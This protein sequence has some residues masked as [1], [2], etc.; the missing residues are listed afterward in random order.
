MQRFCVGRSHFESAQIW[1]DYRRFSLELLSQIFNQNR[2]RIE[3]IHRDVE[4]TLHLLCVQVHGQHTAHTGGVQQIRD[5]F[6]RNRD[7]GLVFPV[8][9]RI[10]KKWNDCCNP[11]RAGAPRRVYH[12]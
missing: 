6:G 5:E 10:S 2:Q 4:E 1:R 3:V 9:A 8:L 7:A 12:D 11:V